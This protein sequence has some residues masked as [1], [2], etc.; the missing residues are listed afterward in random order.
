MPGRQMENHKRPSAP[1]TIVFLIVVFPL[2]ALVTAFLYYFS[3]GHE[4]GQT[5]MLAI[6]GFLLIIASG[7]LISFLLWDQWIRYYREKYEI[8]PARRKAREAIENSNSLL[9]ATIESTADG[10]LVVNAGGR[11]V[12]YNQKFA[13]MWKIPGGLLSRGD[14]K[15]LLSFV[16]DQLVRPESFIDGVNLL[17]SDPAQTTSDSLEFIDGRFF[18]RYSQPQEVNGIVVGRVWSF[19]D[20]T[21]KKQAERDLI[22]AKER[23]EQSDRLKTA[24]LHNV[25][26]EIRTPMNAIIG[27]SMLL[28]ERGI[29]EEERHQYARII[30][31]S[32]N[33]LLSIIN[34]IVDVANVESGLVRLSNS[35]IDLNKTMESLREQFSSTGKDV[36][37]SL[38]TG[39]T[40][41]DAL[42]VTDPEKLMQVLS[43]LLG[44]ALKFTVQGKVDFGYSLNND[45]LEFFVDDTGI[46]MSEELHAKIFERFYQI[47]AS[48]TREYGGTGLGL[49]ICKAYTELLGGRI[50]VEPKQGAGTRFCFT[51]PYIRN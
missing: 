51:V 25:S 1:K 48:G 20:V 32:G 27:F 23:A 39:L 7:L 15:E 4:A 2:I 43:N 24:F 9:K 30:S 12:L 28:G 41:D 35:T 45:E 17:Y 33:Q 22:S 50:W 11:V 44:N 29:S 18:E 47:D 46:G 8:E 21:E 26:H 38:T 36:Q 13:E 37:F 16:K 10:L 42:I 40:G 34:D 14:D 6:I 49:S 5:D 19:R 3:P 31:Q